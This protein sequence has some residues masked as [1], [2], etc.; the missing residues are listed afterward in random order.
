MNFL[1]PSDDDVNV[2]AVAIIEHQFPEAIAIEHE[3]LDAARR[4]A[5]H[6]LRTIGVEL[7]LDKAARPAS[8]A[9]RPR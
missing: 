7:E 6:V 3:T 1:K 5:R 2:V 8:E 9:P 4:L